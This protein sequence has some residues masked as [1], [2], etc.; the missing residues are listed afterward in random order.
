MVVVW[1][2]GL[3]HV[4]TDEGNGV[5]GGSISRGSYWN[6]MDSFGVPPCFRFLGFWKTKKHNKGEMDGYWTWSAATRIQL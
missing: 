5:S 4:F 3:L 2:G 6:E 1:G